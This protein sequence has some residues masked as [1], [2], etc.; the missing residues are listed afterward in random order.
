MQSGALALRLDP[1]NVH[2]LVK[3]C[4]TVV[5]GQMRD[6]EIEFC[7]D[8]SKASTQTLVGDEGRIKQVLVGL[9]NNARKFTARGGTI[10]CSAST[11]NRA[12]GSVVLT[13][14]VHDDGMGFSGPGAA[15]FLPH[16]QQERVEGGVGLGLAIAKD[17]VSQMGGQVHAHSRG[18]GKGAVF[19]FNVSCRLAAGDLKQE[20]A[21]VSL[22]ENAPDRD[23]AQAH[24]M[25]RILCVDD[26]AMLLSI[27]KRQLSSVKHFEVVTCESAIAACSLIEA[28]FES[29]PFSVIVSDVCMAGGI[30]GAELAA[31]VRLKESRYGSR[32]ATKIIGISASADTQTTRRGLGLGFDAFLKKP[33]TSRVIC[34]FFCD[35]KRATVYIPAMKSNA[36]ASFPHRSPEREHCQHN[37][38]CRS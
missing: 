24:P 2:D 23:R 13:I 32:V 35:S 19:E 3:F 26:S 25:V 28:A 29:N 18:P 7:V 38:Y 36:C 21:N 30:D 15:L 33:V 20:L 37:I 17:I 9:L 1:F 12:D 4:D 14:A 22:P 34:E 27:L 8:C 6:K 5:R 10:L 11:A 16:T 31:L